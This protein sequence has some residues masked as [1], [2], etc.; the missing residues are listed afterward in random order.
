MKY[1]MNSEGK[2]HRKFFEDICAIPHGS[3]N[4]KGI[5]DYLVQFAEE[6]GLSC[7]RDQ[8]WNVLIKKEG[9]P[10][11]EKHPPVMLQAHT[12]M[13]CVKKPESDFNF[14][15]DPLQLFVED[16]WLQAKDTTLGADCGHGVAY[17]LAILDDPELAHPPLEAFFSVQEEVGIGGPKFFDY[18]KVQAKKL[19]NFDIFD[20]GLSWISTTSVKGGDFLRKVALEPSLRPMYQLHV[21]G[22]T[23]GHAALDIGNDQANAI[24]IAARFLRKVMKEIHI[25]LAS[26]DGGTARNNIPGECR[27]VFSCNSFFV[28]RLKEITQ[29][30]EQEIKREYAGTDPNLYLKFGDGPYLEKVLTDAS[31]R[32][33]VSFL[34]QLPTGVHMRRFMSNGLALIVPKGQPGDGLVTTSR[35]LGVSKLTGDL[36][37]VGYMFR[38]MMDSQITEMMDQTM[39]L[40]EAFGASWDQ[41]FDYRGHTYRESDPLHTLWNRVYKEATGQEVRGVAAHVG[42]DVGTI[43][44]HIPGMDVM[45]IGPNTLD[46]H[47]PGERMEVA[48]FDRTYDYVKTILSRL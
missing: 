44:Q 24:R 42:T 46:I 25:N 10:G 9:S 28:Q 33:V 11:Y 12:D 8:L 13:V 18:S 36:L 29:E 22:G 43:V 48:S 7:Y 2:P 45:T 16:G 3:Y 39:L 21:G 31:T 34:L 20:E 47:K 14:E 40:A 32:S 30:L 41:V 37:T 15:T 17:M 5:S 27:I 19:I 1:V 4:E 6:R 23:G 38:S 35:N 26:I